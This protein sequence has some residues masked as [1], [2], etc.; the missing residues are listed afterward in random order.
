MRRSL[1]AV[2]E[3]YRV[4]YP[5]RHDRGT[6][7][8][9]SCPDRNGY[10]SEKQR[11]EEQLGAA[12]TCHRNHYLRFDPRD[13]WGQLEAAGIRYDFSVGFNYRMGFRG[14][15]GRA[16]RTFDLATGIARLR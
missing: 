14:G 10:A 13:M 7:R 8:Q 9:L 16:Y 2:A 4:D 5:G 15:C 6:P 11:I 3:D 1:G 12:V